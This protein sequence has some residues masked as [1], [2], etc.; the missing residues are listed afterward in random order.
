MNTKKNMRSN[1]QHPCAKG[2][3]RLCPLNQNEFEPGDAIETTRR[4]F[5]D[6]EKFWT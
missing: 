4:Q 2:H 5:F 6:N 1:F 3:S